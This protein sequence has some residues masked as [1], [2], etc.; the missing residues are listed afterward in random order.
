MQK[1]MTIG[2]FDNGWAW[3]FRVDGHLVDHGWDEDLKTAKRQAAEAAETFRK[4]EK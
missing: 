2:P 4:Q 1:T 3:W